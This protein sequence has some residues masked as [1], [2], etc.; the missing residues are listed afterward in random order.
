MHF[1]VNQNFNLRNLTLRLSLGFLDVQALVL[2]TP[3]PFGLFL[4]ESFGSLSTSF[5]HI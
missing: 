2:T 3:P 5:H 1:V 4:I